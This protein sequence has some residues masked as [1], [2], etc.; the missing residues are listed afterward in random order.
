MILN[1]AVGVVLRSLRA[2]WF[3]CSTLISLQPLNSP[4]GF[5]HHRLLTLHFAKSS[6]EP[7]R[8]RSLRTT[9]TAVVR[10]DASAKTEE[11]RRGSL[12]LSVFRTLYL[13][14]FASGR[15]TENI[16]WGFFPTGEPCLG[17]AAE[18]EPERPLA[19]RLLPFPPIIG[20]FLRF[21]SF[22]RSSRS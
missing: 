10:D 11:R 2:A 16:A 20:D 1:S 8:S 6:N 14:L 4:C 15:A 3:C 7:G 13:T 19:R 12:R 22:P 17:S 18:S 5:R 9:P 21:L